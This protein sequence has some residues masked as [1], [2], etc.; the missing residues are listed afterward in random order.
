LDLAAASLAAGGD[1]PD[2][3]A[4]L[5]GKPLMARW[6][7]FLAANYGMKSQ[8]RKHGVGKRVYDRPYASPPP[9]R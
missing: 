3:A 9:G 8:A 6:L 5:I 7:Y 4:A 2:E 1:I